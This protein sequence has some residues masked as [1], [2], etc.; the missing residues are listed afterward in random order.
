[1]NGNSF[2]TNHKWLKSAE[3]RL[4]NAGIATAH[5]DALVL[6]EDETGH[7]RSWLLAHPE[8]ELSSSQTDKL[9]TK[10]AQRLKHV[11]LAY[12]RG[13]T[14]FFGREFFVSSAVLEPRPESE[15]MI[16]MLI[17]L[18]G[19]D[20]QKFFI[21]DVG[22]GSGAL[23]ITAQLELPKSR[24]EMFEIDKSAIKIAKMNV[25]NF[26]TNISVI[27]SD[28]LSAAPRYYDVLLCNLPYVPDDFH[29]NEAAMNEPRIAI[30]GGPD[31]LDIYR[32]LFDQ[33][34]NFQKKPLYILCESLPPQHEELTAI[35][36]AA[37][38]KL[39]QSDDFIQC[40]KRP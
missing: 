40:F 26:A 2:P 24:V 28:L 15:T 16:E 14:E 17:N 6:L 39:E 25:I 18:P 23:G 34:K 13:K 32:R 10:L 3:Q 19:M 12:V 33:I 22:C 27:E 20:R 4:A 38:Y 37:N 31:G 9:N 5:L 1:M 30:F 11:P 7:D 21:A 36:Q 29:I 35:A 8:L